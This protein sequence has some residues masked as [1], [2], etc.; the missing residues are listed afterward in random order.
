MGN[1]FHKNS[2]RAW[3]RNRAEGG[4]RYGP[5]LLAA[6]AGLGL[7]IGLFELVWYWQRQAQTGFAADTTLLSLAILAVGLVA[8]CLLAAHTWAVTVRRENLEQ[9]VVE[10]S[11]EARAKD[12]Q[13]QHALT[14]V[15]TLR[16]S[17][18]DTV[19]RLM[20]ASVC[21]AQETGMHL[22]RV[23][24]LSEMLAIAA[25]WSH[26]EAQNIRIA[27]PMHD[28]GM[29]GVPDAI[30]NKPGKLTPAE[31][32]VVKM[33][34]LM[35]AKIL[36]GS[37]SSILAMAHKIVLYHH[38][39]WDGTGYPHKLS[40]VD[41]PEPARIVSIVD[42]YDAVSHDRVYRPALPVEEIL[43]ILKKG[44]GTQFDPHLVELF[45]AHY[46]MARDIT[47]NNPDEVMVGYAP[48]VPWFVPSVS[49][50]ALSALDASAPEPSV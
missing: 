47:R 2:I 43:D 28:V 46:D 33:H 1:S 31:F 13:L 48:S 40:K 7:T 11:T 34:T 12:E 10:R 21:R 22:R 20:K 26:M 50:N 49:F 18:E 8:T 30:L 45:L 17:Y 37:P 23:G 27:A 41:I 24:M 25:G 38:E 36:D 16:V 14:R 29:I 35:G 9:L 42:V 15:R 39:R 4:G 44:A 19:Q 5:T 32:E 6:V 3:F